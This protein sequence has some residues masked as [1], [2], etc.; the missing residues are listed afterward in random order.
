MQKAK[1]HST[2]IDV[3]AARPLKLQSDLVKLL[4]LNGFNVTQASVSRDLEELGIVKANGVYQLPAAAFD[5]SSF[6][7]R[8]IEPCGD[9]LL[10][11]RCDS[12]LASAITVR[13][14]AAKID[15]IVGTIAGD[16]TIFIAVA[17]KKRIRGISAKIWALFTEGK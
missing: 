15:G 2:I 5:T 13:I 10:V 9:N 16:D 12:G 14:D 3:V 4:R 7:L 8:S 11:I 1:R 17:D 6:G